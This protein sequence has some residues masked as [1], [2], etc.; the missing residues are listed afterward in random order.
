[1][2]L[3]LQNLLRKRNLAI[4]GLIALV[5]VIGFFGFQ[6]LM[7]KEKESSNSN[8]LAE[9]QSYSYL[10][11]KI[12]EIANENEMVSDFIQGSDGDYDSSISIIP[13]NKL[14]VLCQ[15]FPEI[16]C[17]LPQKDLFQVEYNYK[18]WGILAIIDLEGNKTL[19]VFRT[20]NSQNK[21][22]GDSFCTISEV[23]NN[24]L[25]ST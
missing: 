7:P 22:C 11:K 19:K 10:S 23:E 4:F 15:K 9:S 20:I 21:N 8:N 3:S 18:Y 17:N 24:P 12:Y 16:Y 13:K 5:L 2:D 6:A 14:N 1:M 25:V